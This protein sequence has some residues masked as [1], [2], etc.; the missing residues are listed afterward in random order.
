MEQL[1]G[2]PASRYIL[3]CPADS[4]AAFAPLAE[5]CGFTIFCGA[6]DD[7]LGRYCAAIRH[8][9]LDTPAGSRIIRATGDNPFVFAE[10]AAAINEEAAARGADYAAYSGLPYGAG[11][12]SAAA[13]ALL[14][15]EA[16]SH[17]SYDR[18]HVCPYLYAHPQQFRLHRPAAPSPWQG[19]YRITVDTPADYARAGALFAVLHRPPPIPA[20]DII[21]AAQCLSE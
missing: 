20:V 18:E 5:S 7:V 3:A 14:C 19:D 21:R 9:K 15:A 11:V 17:A 1:R 8:F 12:E 6:K 10:A 2:V 4:E 16:E 13:A